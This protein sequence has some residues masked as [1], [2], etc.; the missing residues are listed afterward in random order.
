[1]ASSLTLLG[2]AGGPTP[3]GTR[4][5]PA[6]VVT[7]DGSAYVIDCGNGVADQL[8][9]ADIPFSALRAAFI[10][11]NHSDHNADMGNLLLLGWSGI[12]KPVR[13]HGPAPLAAPLK[14]FFEMQRYDIDTRVHDEGR[15]P[16]DEL[17][18]VTE[19]TE[20]G[21]VY[22]DELVTV[23][24]TLVDHPPVA[25]ALGYRIDTPDRSIVFSGDTRPSDALVEL[26]R[27][28]DVLVHEAMYVPALSGLLSRLNGDSMR[29][30]L[31]D[32][33]TRVDEAGQVAQRAGVATLVL[34]HFVPADDSV[35]DDVW[36]AEAAR[37]FSGDIVVGKDLMRL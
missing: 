28:A 21:V 11:H 3:Q 9:R 36:H 34:N 18:E 5:A 31:L 30:H 10:T 7:V 2:T 13:L 16:L 37:T 20:P 25:P 15:R 22:Q 29:K 12:S 1:M 27:G 6:N 33:H 26:A 17:V 19:I 24:A 23:T 8:V 14:N 4:H 32:S 35:S